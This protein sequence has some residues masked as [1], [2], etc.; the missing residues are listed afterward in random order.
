MSV[1]VCRSLAQYGGQHGV[2][3]LT[4]SF[5]LLHSLT[6]TT[7]SVLL[8]ASGVVDSF[9]VPALVGGVVLAHFFYASIL[10]CLENGAWF[11]CSVEVDVW[12]FAII[13]W[14]KDVGNS[15]NF[16][17]IPFSISTSFRLDTP[18][19]A[20]DWDNFAKETALSIYHL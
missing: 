10:F 3:L 17:S 13:V 15:Q 4:P 8:P 19:K 11:L 20:I 18:I 6:F 12:V 2:H 16:K 5:A 1:N 14:H 7:S 9:A